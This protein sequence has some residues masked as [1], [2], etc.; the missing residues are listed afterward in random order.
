MTKIEKQAFVA[1]MALALV[2]FAAIFIA[3]GFG[4]TFDGV[5]Q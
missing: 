2:A 1:S 5:P 3:A 4:L